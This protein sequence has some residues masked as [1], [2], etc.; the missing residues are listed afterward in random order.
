M[1]KYSKTGCLA[2]R[3]WRISTQAGASERDQRW[4]QEREPEFVSVGKAEESRDKHGNSCHS[5]WGH[6]GIKTICTDVIAFN[7]HQTSSTLLSIQQR[8]CKHHSSGHKSQKII[9][10]CIKGNSS[11]C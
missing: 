8:L 11:S 10:V 5:P 7:T 6:H 3:S 1:F 9:K 4:S 2:S